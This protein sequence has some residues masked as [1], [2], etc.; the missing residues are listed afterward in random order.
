ML[1]S[2]YAYFDR[3]NVGLPGE[4][5]YVQL[6]NV[7]PHFLAHTGK[8]A[9]CRMAL[10][11]VSAFASQTINIYIYV[12]EYITVY[13]DIYC[14]RCSGQFFVLDVQQLIATIIGQSS[15]SRV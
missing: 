3:D 12:L 4:P 10:C 8:V 13:Y 9:A 2:F 15:K 5:P 7:V 14:K 1:C 6:Q 11:R